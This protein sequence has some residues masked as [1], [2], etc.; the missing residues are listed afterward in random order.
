MDTGSLDQLRDRG[1][2]VLRGAI[3]PA[4]I[5]EEVEHALRDAYAAHDAFETLAQGSGTVTFRYVPMMCERTPVSLG[6]VDALAVVAAELLGRP[7]VPGRAKGTRYVGDTGW[8]RDS[9]HDIAS[10]GVVAY[11]EPLRAETG[12]LRVVPGSHVRREAPLP[13]DGAVTGE[14]LETE[15]GDVIV[16]DEHLIHGSSGGNE[17]RQWRVDFLID[18]RDPGEHAAAAA[19]FDQSI[20]SERSGQ[21]YDTERYPSYGAYC[22]TRDRPW[23][24]RLGELGAYRRS[25]A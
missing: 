16:F 17:R 23:T 10:V 6:L 11:L 21:A 15:P 19:W 22:R 1:F 13:A 7:V 25:M 24:A 14:A 5:S 18:P 20:P 12:A 8:H 9:A 2:L 3:D 4:P